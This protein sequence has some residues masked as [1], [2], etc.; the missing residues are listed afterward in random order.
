[1]QDFVFKMAEDETFSVTGYS[2]NEEEV[3]IPDTHWGR[4]V[5]ILFDDLFRGHAEIRT[6]R[7]PDTVTDI[8]EFVFDGCENLTKVT[9]PSTL[10]HIWPYAFARC[11]IEELVIP[12]GVRSI[13]PFT[14]K[15]CRSLRKV[16]CGTGMK[17]IYAYAFGGCGRLSEFYFEPGCEISPLAFEDKTLNT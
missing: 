17:K 12:D 13:A 9:L 5:T 10:E 14:F 16:T 8:G 11:S 4:P 6:V 7:I 1:M 15:D 3:V 2:G